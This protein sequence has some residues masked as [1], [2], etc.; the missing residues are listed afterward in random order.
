MNSTG[1]VNKNIVVN[2]VDSITDNV[3]YVMYLDDDKENDTKDV[4]RDVINDI[5]DN[6]LQ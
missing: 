4:R 5:A 3:N 2:N 1:W 6:T